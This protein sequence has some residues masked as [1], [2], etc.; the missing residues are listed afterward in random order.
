MII[1][2]ALGIVLAVV[3]LR[4]LPLASLVFTWSLVILFIVAL[5]TF[6]AYNWKVTI[7]IILVGLFLILWFGSFI[8]VFNKA[9]NYIDEKYKNSNQ[10]KIKYF[11]VLALILLAIIYPLIGRGLFYFLEPFYKNLF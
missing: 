6:V 9:L 10:N 1:E 4:L 8:I 3:I 11:K 7:G 2:I 5:I